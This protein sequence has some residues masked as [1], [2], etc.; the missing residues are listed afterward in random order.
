ME[1]KM[2]DDL[3]KRI[4]A[5]EDEL[6]AAKEEAAAKAK[7]AEKAKEPFKLKEPWKRYDPTEGL[8]MSGSAVR[9]MVDVVPDMRGIA[10]EQGRVSVP[11]MFPAEQGEPKVRGSGWREPR[12]L[13][14]P[15]GLKWIDRQVDVA[16]ALDRRDLERRLRQGVK[17]R[18]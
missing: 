10:R 16:D 11:G 4:A 8:R 14:G 17:R 1:A 2:S 18:I 9:A 12:P 6:K 15:P 13:E 5:L 3:E 7:A